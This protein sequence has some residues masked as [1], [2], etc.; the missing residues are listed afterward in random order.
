MNEVISASPTQ[1]RWIVISVTFA[2]FLVVLDTYI[3]NVSLPS[4]AHF[5]NVSTSDVVR[6]VVAYLLII[7][8]SLPLLG[9]LGDKFGFK[10]LLTFGFCIFTVGSFLCGIS[11]T[12]NILIICRCIQGIGGAILYA[13]GT[14]LIPRY[15]PENRRGRAFGIIATAA[16]LGMSLGAPVGGF[17]TQWLSW[18]WIFLINVPAG[19]AAVF[20]V[21]HAIPGKDTPPAGHHKTSSFDFAG[22]V[23][24]LL[25]LLALVYALNRGQEASWLSPTVISLFSISAILLAAFFIWEKR[26]ADP[27][28]D[29]TL[30][31]IKGFRYAALAG[32]NFLLPFYLIYIKGLS[33]STTGLVIMIYSVVYM[34]A[35]PL[36]GR[37]SDK[38]HP[39]VLFSSGMASAMLAFIFFAFILKLP[40]LLPVIVFIIWLA[41]SLS[42]F[43]APNNNEIMNTAPVDKQGIS[44]AVYRTLQ[45]LGMVLGVSLL[46]TIFSQYIPVNEMTNSLSRSAVSQD[47]LFQGFQSAYLAG[48]V[49]C[50]AGLVLSVLAKAKKE[51]ETYKA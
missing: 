11:P 30:F 50:G 10:R 4:I 44:S 49:I 3:V 45:N 26:C 2:S 1:Q 31:K 39:A 24:S 47:V 22:A 20:V 33:M 27:L 19:I 34:I 6:V 16:G 41:L 17:I 12:L 23:L 32:N 42:A 25:G 48:A 14:A 51:T 40:G 5:F 18:H 46:E 8:S 28:I 35:S 21:L 15:L 13:I 36:M 7:T 9:K 29:L 38:I 43:I 37:L